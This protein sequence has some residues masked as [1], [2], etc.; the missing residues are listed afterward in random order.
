M[1]LLAMQCATF[2]LVTAHDDVSLHLCQA[3]AS[4]P[5]QQLHPTRRP[6]AAHEFE[7]LTS[8]AVVPAGAPDIALLKRLAQRKM[9]VV[10]TGPSPDLAQMKSLE[11]AGER[12]TVMPNHY[13]CIGK[14]SLLVLLIIAWTAWAC[15]GW[16]SGWPLMITLPVVTASKHTCSV[17][18][19]IHT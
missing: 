9:W 12:M 17:A 19:H 14:R 8:A 6:D 2:D 4:G 3:P 16:L 15:V 13:I 1:L 18:I 7:A 11:Q 5:V 10:K